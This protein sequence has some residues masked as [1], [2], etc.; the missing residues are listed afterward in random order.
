MALLAD[1]AAVEHIAAALRGRKRYLFI[2]DSQAA[3]DS[4][5]QLGIA[6]YVSALAEGRGP[7]EM[8]AGTFTWLDGV[9]GLKVEIYF[10]TVKK[11]RSG[12]TAEVIRRFLGSCGTDC[13]RLDIGGE[14][15]LFPIGVA[16]QSMNRLLAAIQ[17][18][19]VTTMAVPVGSSSGR[20]AMPSAN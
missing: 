20:A 7:P 12:T 16:P 11:T 19:K 15:D 10:I 14:H 6:I 18:G 3:F 8:T 1:S 2:T 5:S 13:T 9:T 17:R 4:V